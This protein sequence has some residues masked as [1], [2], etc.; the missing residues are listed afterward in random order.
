MRPPNVERARRAAEYLKE[1]PNALD[2]LEHVIVQSDL[3]ALDLTPQDLRDVQAGAEKQIEPETPRG[4]YRTRA[5][6]AED[7]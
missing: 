6:E 5:V 1:H 7:K 3:V 4:K 2:E